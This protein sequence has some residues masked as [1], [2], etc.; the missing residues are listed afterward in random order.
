MV[1]KLNQLM[2]VVN[3]GVADDNDLPGDKETKKKKKE[4]NTSAEAAASIALP[5]LYS[6]LCTL[7]VLTAPPPSLPN[8]HAH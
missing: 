4:S 2:S 7:V 5:W 6:L 1:R 8:H 3:R